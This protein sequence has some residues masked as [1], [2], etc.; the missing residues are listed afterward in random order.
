MKDVDKKL[1]EALREDDASLFG[2]ADE[3]SMFGDIADTFRGKRRWLVIMVWF[4]AFIAA[5]LMFTGAV[6]FFKAE[7]ESDKLAWGL[8]CI[9]GMLANGLLKTWYWME[10]NRASVMREIKRVELQIARL[11]ERLPPASDGEP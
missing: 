10:M 8:G 3:R 4:W 5:V 11:A 7:S 1:A 2:V 6:M 9:F